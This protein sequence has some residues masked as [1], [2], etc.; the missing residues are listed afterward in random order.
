MRL[1]NSFK[2]QCAFFEFDLNFDQEHQDIEQ[3]LL[4]YYHQ[5]DPEVIAAEGLEADYVLRLLPKLSFS[6]G[7]ALKHPALHYVDL[8]C[9]TAHNHVSIILSPQ[10]PLFTQL[11]KLYDMPPESTDFNKIIQHLQSTYMLEALNP[12]DFCD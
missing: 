1:F 7:I 4:H 6:S 8:S 11:K 3:E 9:L 5:Y 12:K 2:E 10:H